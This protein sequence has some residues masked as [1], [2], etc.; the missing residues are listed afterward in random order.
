MWKH[1]SIK[2]I[3]ILW[4]NNGL[5]FDMKDFYNS[6]EI[7]HET[8]YVDTPQQNE[9]VERKHEQLLNIA[10]ALHFQASIPIKV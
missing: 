8:S 2:R 6:K 5:K 4:S 7:L 10:H 3:N 1:N 9:V